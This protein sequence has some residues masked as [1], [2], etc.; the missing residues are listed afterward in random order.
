ME[1]KKKLSVK[2]KLIINKIIGYGLLILPVL[3]VVCVKWKS[4]FTKQNGVALSL[5]CAVAIVCVTLG[6]LK[7]FEIFKGIVGETLILV[8]AW[9][10]NS[11]LDQFLLLYA[12]FY[13]C[14][15]IYR[16]GFQSRIKRLEAMQTEIDK[17]NATKEITQ[18]VNSDFANELAKR[19]KG[20][21]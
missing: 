5:G 15:I 14:D 21:V 19:L 16:I 17:L 20:S 4:Y 13:V 6:I 9:C 2:Q 10:F 3:V 7:K 18:E 12:V 1:N 8:L 11:I